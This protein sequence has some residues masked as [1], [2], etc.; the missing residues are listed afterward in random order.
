MTVLFLAPSQLTAE[1]ERLHNL[2]S[3]VHYAQQLSP[4][5]RAA[6]LERFGAP[7]AEPSPLQGSDGS[8]QA[9]FKA[10]LGGFEGRTS[11]L[12]ALLKELAGAV[13]TDQDGLRLMA[14][15]RGQA[16]PDSSAEGGVETHRRTA[17]WTPGL[18]QRRSG[19]GAGLARRRERLAATLAEDEELLAAAG[20]GG[21]GRSPGSSGSNY[22]AEQG[23]PPLRGN[24]A[25]HVGQG[26]RYDPVNLKGTAASPNPSFSPWA[27]AC[28]QE[29]EAAAEEEGTGTSGFE[30]EERDYAES[31]GGG[32]AVAS[33]TPPPP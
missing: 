23:E 24:R 7:L 30:G 11:V 14:H 22:F 18:S 25:S 1:E 29:E 17:Q 26:D 8:I 9:S 2:R 28:P 5:D 6:F 32:S 20:L 13:R 31:I 3:A 4:A 15:L 33:V 19:G 27:A 12:A 21:A 16:S 10:L